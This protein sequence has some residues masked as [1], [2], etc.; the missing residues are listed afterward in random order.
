MRFSIDPS[1]IYI[2]LGYLIFKFVSLKAITISRKPMVY[3]EWY[4]CSKTFLFKTE[5]VYTVRHIIWT[6]FFTLNCLFSFLYN[7]HNTLLVKYSTTS[8]IG[9]S[10][11]II[12]K[13]SHPQNFFSLKNNNVLDYTKRKI[14]SKYVLSFQKKDKSTENV[15]ACLFC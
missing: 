10:W 3:S 7:Y 5:A 11:K 14:M 1:L 6:L 9:F 8:V 15:K 4:L 12:C 13:C 2:I